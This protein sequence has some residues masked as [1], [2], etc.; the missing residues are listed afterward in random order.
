MPVRSL[1]LSHNDF[2]CPIRLAHLTTLQQLTLQSGGFAGCD[3]NDPAQVQLPETLSVLDVS[4]MRGA[5]ATHQPF[6]LDT[7]IFCVV[8]CLICSDCAAPL[9]LTFHCCSCAQISDIAWSPMSLRIPLS[10]A[11]LRARNASVVAVTR[12]L[13]CVLTT[14]VLDDNALA[15]EQ[16]ATSFENILFLAD[17]LQVLSCQRCGLQLSVTQLIPATGTMVRI[18][19]QELHVA[20]VG[21]TLGTCHACAAAGD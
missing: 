13:R 19:L 11:S 8:A 9:F 7:R 16:Q 6:S 20:Q 18:V 3:F 21:R 14:L 1:L 5:R 17:T 4:S 2:S 12:T 15:P 10:L